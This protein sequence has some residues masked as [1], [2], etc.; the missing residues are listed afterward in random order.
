MWL[1]AI[2]AGN[3][4][5]TLSRHRRGAQLGFVKLEQPRYHPK[6]TVCAIQAR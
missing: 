2:S 4:T 1:E 3:V 6:I 5:F